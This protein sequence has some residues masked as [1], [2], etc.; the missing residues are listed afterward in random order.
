MTR[1]K[2]VSVLGAV[3]VALGVTL[4]VPTTAAADTV[5]PTILADLN[6]D[7]ILDQV[8]FSQIGSFTSTACAVTVSNGLASGGFGPPTVHTYKSAEPIAP[9]CPD[10][11]VAMKMGNQTLPD[12][13][14]A[15][16]FGG[17]DL[18]DLHNFQPVAT[19]HGLNQPNWLRTGDLNGD[20]RPD[21]I[22]ASMQSEFLGTRLNT[23]QGT[24]VPG[25]ISAC[26]AVN[27]GLPQYVLADFNGDRH[28]D[29]LLSA[30]CPG[31]I[32]AEVLF[33][34]GQ[35]PA[36]LAGTTDFQAR[37][38]VFSIDLNYDGIPDA[39]VVE[40]SGTGVTT[41]QYFQNDGAGH[42]TPVP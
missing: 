38:T 36:V 25:P 26:V 14:T 27:S 9:F 29:M 13:I 31:Q 11:A 33:T 24:L 10:L 3:L 20:G 5:G 32:K 7:G 6:G 30:N 19:F 12:L 21:L 18:V 8:V 39:G 42:F 28:N 15:F 22:E 40:V 16:G 23:P 4:S 1:T 35:A 37:W 34:N 17:T 41:V 2:L